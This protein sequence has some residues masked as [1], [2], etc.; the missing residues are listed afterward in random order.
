MA[1]QDGTSKISLGN[2]YLATL[3][4][5]NFFLISILNLPSFYFKAITCVLS[6]HFLIESFSS[7]LVGPIWMDIMD[8][9]FFFFS[10][11]MF[12][13]QLYMSP[14]TVF[15]AC[16]KVAKVDRKPLTRFSNPSPEWQKKQLALE[17][18]EYW[19]YS[20]IVLLLKVDLKFKLSCLVFL[21]RVL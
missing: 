8:I 13:W 7:L 18:R 20:F 5:Q 6:V 10:V 15:Q 21:F 11:H 14:Q 19:R 17:F 2:L 9:L 3:A 12:D 16:Y 4:V 1:F